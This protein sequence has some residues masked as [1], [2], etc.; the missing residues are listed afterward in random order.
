MYMWTDSTIVLNWLSGNPRGLKTFVGNCESFIMN[1]VPPNRWHHVS[2]LDNPVDCAS[3]GLLPSELR[4][5]NLWWDG[6]RWLTLPSSERP[7]QSKVKSVCLPEEERE[8]CLALSVRVR[9]PVVPL[10]KYSSFTRVKPITA[11]MFRFINN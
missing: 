9:D 5:F 1:H 4:E 7:D 11:W 10:N 3:R 6:P 2:G 8:V